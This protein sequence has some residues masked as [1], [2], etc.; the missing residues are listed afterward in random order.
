MKRRGIFLRRGCER[1]TWCCCQRSPAARPAEIWHCKCSAQ[2]RD[3]SRQINA[4][5]SLMET[6]YRGLRVSY[7]VSISSLV[8]LETIT[9]E[10]QLVLKIF[11]WA[12][13]EIGELVFNSL[14]P[15]LCN[16]TPHW[17]QENFLLSKE[18]SKKCPSGCFCTSEAKG[19][20]FHR[21]E[22]HQTHS[23]LQH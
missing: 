3:A 6:M 15:F 19:K 8:A 23:H 13:T 10:T 17:L 1:G 11:H 12:N 16:P 5:F 21:S 7:L 22:Q 4:T 9:K 2:L 14:S 18:N 20:L